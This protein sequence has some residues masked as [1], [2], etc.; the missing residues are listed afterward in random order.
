MF[1]FNFSHFPVDFDDNCNYFS[2]NRKLFLI[3]QNYESVKKETLCSIKLMSNFLKKLIDLDLYE[4]STIVL[5]SDHGT[6]SNYFIKSK[7]NINYDINNH[8]L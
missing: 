3:N 6:P 8:K 5:K 1:H 2:Y 7:F 4:N